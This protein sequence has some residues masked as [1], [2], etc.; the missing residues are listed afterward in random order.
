MHKNIQN[1][2]LSENIYSRPKTNLKDVKGIVW[3]WVANPKTTAMQNREFF[4]LRKKGNYGYGSA[5]FIIG[6]NGEIIQCIPVCEIAY[7]VGAKK[8]TKL[9]RNKLGRYPNNCTLGIELCHID[10]YGNMTNETIGSLLALTHYLCKKFSLNTKNIYRHYDITE[11]LC[12]LYLVKNNN[13]Y[14][15]LKYLCFNTYKTKIIIDNFELY[16]SLI[17]RNNII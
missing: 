9:A 10:E 2:L 17:H 8:Y 15:Y 11:K 1:I 7:H 13:I 6:I 4:E 3:H 16:D 14:E 5:H 12:P